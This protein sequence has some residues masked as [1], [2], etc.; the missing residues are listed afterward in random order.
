MM[1]MKMIDHGNNG[2][3]EDNVMMIVMMMTITIYGGN[4]HDIL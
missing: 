2:G 4:G 1:I 3:D